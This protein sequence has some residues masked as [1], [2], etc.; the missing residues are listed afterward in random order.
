MNKALKKRFAEL[1]AIKEM[2]K[3]QTQKRIEKSLTNAPYK[4]P[5]IKIKF[6]PIGGDDMI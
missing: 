2:Q 5:D 6:V 4:H 3:E 1:H